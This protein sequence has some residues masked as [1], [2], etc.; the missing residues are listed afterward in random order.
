MWPLSQSVHRIPGVRG[1][2]AYLVASAQGLVLVDCGFPNNGPRIVAFLESRGFAPRSLR[3]IV[4]THSDPDH[5]G[6]AAE[7]K[8]LTGAEVAVHE[9][10]APVLAGGLTAR[11][12]KGRLTVRTFLPRLARSGHELAMALVLRWPGR[13]SRW[14]PVSAD[15]LLRAGDVICGLRVD[16]A[17]GHTAGSIALR[18]EDGV[19][20][21]GDAVFGDSAGRAHY[22]PW[23]TALDP[24]QA[25]AT[26]H[27]LVAAGFA[28][29]YPGHGEPITAQR[30]SADS[31][32]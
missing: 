19:V 5:S 22:P 8:A 28:T 4:L 31:R 18:S 25:R 10:D 2:N 32:I 3:T 11:R 12:A 24:A 23:T 20:F 16:H 6:S 13:R 30:S 26:A 29:L 21:T 17:P 9:H 1:A 15:L 27:R 14:R 7:L